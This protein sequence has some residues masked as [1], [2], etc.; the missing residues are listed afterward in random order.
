[1]AAGP[2][3]GGATAAVEEIEETAKLVLLTHGMKTRLLTP[4]QIEALRQ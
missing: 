3:L 2:P 4:A 1:M